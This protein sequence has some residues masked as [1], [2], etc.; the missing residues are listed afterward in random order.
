MIGRRRHH[1][2]AREPGAPEDTLDEL[3]D[4]ASALADQSDHDH[5]GSGIAR[6]H[7]EQHALADSAAGEQADALAAP[8]ASAAH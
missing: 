3:L 4:L 6:H 7:A 8:D 5:V 2:R 1:H